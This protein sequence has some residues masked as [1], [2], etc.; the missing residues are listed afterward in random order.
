MIDRNTDGQLQCATI[1]KKYFP[2][3]TTHNNNC[4][5]AA[6]SWRRLSFFGGLH[7]ICH[8]KSKQNYCI[9]FNFI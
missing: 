6:L 1:Y 3:I 9:D 5:A 8:K 2:N 7:T 4:K